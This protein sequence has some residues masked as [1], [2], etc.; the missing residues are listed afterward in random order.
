LRISLS[1]LLIFSCGEQIN[2]LLYR[3]IRL[4][5]RGLDFGGRRRCGG[6]SVMKEGV[7]HGA[8]DALVEEDKHRRDFEALGRQLVSSRSSPPSTKPTTPAGS[9]LDHA[10]REIV[11]A[12]FFEIPAEAVVNAANEGRGHA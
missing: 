10:K 4:V 11:A 6:G 7:G 3:D 1:D 2:E 12:R 9:R 8:T 5:V